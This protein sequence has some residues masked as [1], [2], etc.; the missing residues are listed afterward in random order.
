M[1]KE[2]IPEFNGT[3]CVL[4]SV[5]TDEDDPDLDGSFDAPTSDP[6]RQLQAILK[7]GGGGGCPWPT[8][9]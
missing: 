3:K 1:A 6:R 5:Y 8:A 4:A 2:Q 9:P 7:G